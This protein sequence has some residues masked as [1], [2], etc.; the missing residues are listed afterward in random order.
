MSLPGRFSVLVGANGVGKTTVSD[1]I[2]LGHREHFPQLPQLSSAALGDG[3]C[4]VEVEYS[5]D[6][7]TTT[8]GPFGRQLQ[9]QSS[10]NAAGTVATSWSKT[11]TRRMGRIGTETLVH[12]EHERLI[13][14]V[15]LPAWR[16]PLDELA[17]RETR[18]LV[19]LLRAQQQ[20]LG[21]GRNLSSLRA[22]A[23]NLL[24]ALATDD[25]LV[26]LEERVG[27][28]L[29]ALSAGV[30]RNW[31]YVGGQ[32][33]DDRYLARVL[34]LMLAIIEG[35]SNA[36][37]LEVS[38]LGYVNLLHIA[39]TLAA[40]PDLQAQADAD[41][42]AD[43]PHAEEMGDVEA[44][45]ERLR[46]AQA[47][48]ESIEDS[49]F[50]ASPFHVTVLIE[51]PEAHLHPQLQHSLVRY[52]RREVQRRPELQVILSTHATDII[53]SCDPEE[54]VVL[55]S[56]AAG[57]R[58][59]RA[60]ASIPM[61]RR[62]EVLRMTRLHLD[63]NRS[64]S[65][66]AERVLLVEGVTEAAVIREFGWVWAGS[67]RDKEAFVDALSIVPM[68]TKVGPWAV[69]LLATRG[70]EL[71]RRIAVLRDSDLAL[72]DTPEQPE[73]AL[74]HDDAVLLVE[75][76]HPTLEPQI[77]PGNDGL[78]VQALADVDLD[79]PTPLDPPAI[80]A[81][82]RGRH[83]ENGSAVAAGPGAKK[84]AEFALA[85]AQRLREARAVDSSGVKVP[86]P[87]RNVFDFLYKSLEIPAPPPAPEEPDSALEVEPA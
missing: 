39:V 5:F 56:D 68:M 25:L 4:T 34:E 87:M 70:H 50:P 75:H 35:R 77:T 26:G 74:D 20:N 63:T 44:A 54:L 36:R 48:R 46:Q 8:E 16:N 41:V 1:A 49:F 11:L 7:D 84:K 61:K 6:A 33:V 24:E 12:S 72:G 29:Y 82:F 42:V 69:R 71:C 81:L 80:H 38:G 10:R 65:L 76:C 28:H 14:L 9:A 31:P 60:I 55:R 51:E 17:R 57:R 15:H 85:L 58:V 45:S 78:V 30:S 37:P 66:F 40:I 83:Q 3:T 86:E 59:S 52:L 47:E 73:W 23:S 18:V 2:Y 62:A 67:D 21:R 53:T 22:R 64:A 19:E 32:V 27:N 43:A 79:I 13:R